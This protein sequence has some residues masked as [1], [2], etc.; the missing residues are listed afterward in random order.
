MSASGDDP[1]LKIVSQNEEINFSRTSEVATQPSH[2]A[3]AVQLDFTRVSSA[4]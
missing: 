2:P 4:K 1:N 3:T